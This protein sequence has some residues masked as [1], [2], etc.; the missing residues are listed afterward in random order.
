MRKKAEI[1][2]PVFTDA[3]IPSDNLTVVIAFT[4]RDFL[5]WWFVQMPVV[6]IS[7]LRR[8]STVL[9][10]KLS[11]TLL[12]KTFFVPWHRD[13]SFVGYIVGFVMRLLYLPIALIIYF[14]VVIGA[15]LGVFLWIAM[16]MIA[17]ILII[18]T[19]LIR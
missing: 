18:L 12:L 19:P 16:P 4:A 13:N 9:N 3:D 8:L 6:Y 1:T 7:F 2:N 17:G 15:T 10:D 11:I 14:S 5:D